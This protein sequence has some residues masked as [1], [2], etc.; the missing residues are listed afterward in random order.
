MTL[1]LTTEWRGKFRHTFVHDNDFDLKE[2][3]NAVDKVR[4]GSYQFSKSNNIGNARWYYIN[5]YHAGTYDD[6]LKTREWREFRDEVI[7][8]YENRCY[9][10][11]KRKARQSSI[12]LRIV[13]VGC[14]SH[15]IRTVLLG[16]LRPQ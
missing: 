11:E 2:I 10:C 13:S 7:E 15:M 16:S 12:I 8:F 4:P 14:L 5:H 9:V 3:R 1:K 6:F